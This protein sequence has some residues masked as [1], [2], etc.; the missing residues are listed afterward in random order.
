MNEPD[1]ASYE[2][3]DDV[4]ESVWD[5][6]SIVVRD[7]AGTFAYAVDDEATDTKTELV[8]ADH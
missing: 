1:A 4:V 7:G 2:R 6:P 3:G 5:H 8:G